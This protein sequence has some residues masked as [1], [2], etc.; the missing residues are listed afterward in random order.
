LLHDTISAY[1]GTDGIEGQCFPVAADNRLTKIQGFWDTLQKTSG[2]Y[3]RRVL[4]HTP[5]DLWETLQNTSRTHI[6][7]LG[8]YL[9][10]FWDIQWRNYGTYS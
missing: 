7:N 2:A 9:E 8:V 6:K 5:V 10:E 1:K 3:A 4:Q